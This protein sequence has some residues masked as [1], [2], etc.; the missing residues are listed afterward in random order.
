ML[1]RKHRLPGRP[2]PPRALPGA[3]ADARVRTVAER[4]VGTAAAAAQPCLHHAGDDAP[5]ATGNLEVPAHPQRP[6][7]FRLYSQRTVADR[8]HVGLAGRGLAGRRELDLVMR[9][10]AIGLVLRGTAAA[11]GGAILSSLAAEPQVRAHRVRTAFANGNQIHQR[12]LFLRLAVLSPV[13]DRAGGTHM[14]DL[15]QSLR[16]HGVRMNPRTGYAGEE[17][18][19]SPG[20]P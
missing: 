20:D 19:R 9:A 13:A 8:Q 14:R 7:G 15:G 16:V 3:E 6:V 12:R 4:L 17:N 10:I 1:R 11:E 18:I 2:A 5:G